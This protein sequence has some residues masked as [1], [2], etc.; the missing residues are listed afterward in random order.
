MK[1]L[2]ITITSFFFAQFLKFSYFC[3]VLGVALTD[4]PIGLAA[5]ILE[6]FSGGT[7]LTYRSLY[8]GGLTK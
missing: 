8:D 7:N 2:G 3:N 4:S 6:K 1:N 5:Y